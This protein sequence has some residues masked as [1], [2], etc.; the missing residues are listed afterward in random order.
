MDE[1]LAVEEHSDPR[2]A[3]AR[4]EARIEALTAKIENCRKYIL[5]SQVAVA[6]G[7][8]VILAGISGLIRL[9]AMALAAA[10]VAVIGG[11]VLLGSNHS[12]ARE[13]AAELDE[14]ER[15]RAALIGTLDLHSVGAQD[16]VSIH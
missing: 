6:L 11:I 5:A 1:R 15:Q 10:V 2:E 8:L 3:I 16:N 14:A 9:D 7:V 4:M 13:A 12:T